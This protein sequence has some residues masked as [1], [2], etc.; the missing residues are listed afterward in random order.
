MQRMCAFVEKRHVQKPM[1][2]IKMEARPNDQK[3]EHQHKPHWVFWKQKRRR[4]SVCHRPV[5]G[6]LKGRPECDA[7]RDG[8]KHVVMHLVAERESAV[9]FGLITRI[10]FGMLVLPAPVIEP[11]M[12]Q[13]GAQAMRDQVRQINLQDPGPMPGLHRFQWWQKRIEYEDRKHDRHRRC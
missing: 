12:Q 11:H 7:R 6:R 5:D 1:H 13:T 9:V 10:E 4:V 8:P 3:R 2:P